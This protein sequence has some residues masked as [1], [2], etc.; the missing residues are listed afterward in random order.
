MEESMEFLE[1]NQTVFFTCVKTSRE[2]SCARLL[3][4]S[5]RTFGGPL[6]SAPILIFEAS[7]HE[8]PC[9][10]LVIEGVRTVM[11]NTP[12][13]SRSYFFSNKVWACAQAEKLTAQSTRSLVW[14]APEVLIVQPPVGF[15]LAANFDAALRPVHIRN[16]GSLSGSLLDVFWRGVYDALGIEDVPFD[17]V[18]FVDEQRLRAYFNTAAL[19]INPAHGIFRRWYE[20]F[21]KLV[22]DQAFQSAACQD[23]L[24]RIFLHQAILC[25]LIVTMLESEKIRMLPPVYGYPYN[26]QPS[27]G[28]K[29]RVEIL[30]DLVCAVY[31]ERSLHPEE[32]D[33]TVNE[34]LR[35]WILKYEGTEPVIR[36]SQ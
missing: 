32:M 29:Q 27:I 33:I 1:D 36:Q 4:D 3:I 8:V 26:L 35:S 22:N 6:S 9:D 13:S 19:C 2:R 5:I 15:D 14:L 28:E 23:D 31:E 34:P 21:E 11:L 20:I 18:S 7:P 10:E 30:N 25:P 24:H 17:V 12:D 16:V